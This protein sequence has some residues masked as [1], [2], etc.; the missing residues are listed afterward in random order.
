[1][2]ELVT[3]N[4]GQ[5]RDL[6]PI[7]FINDGN[8][9]RIEKA[10]HDICYKV[11]GRLLLI[12]LRIALKIN[13][14]HVRDYSLYIEP[15]SSCCVFQHYVPQAE[16]NDNKLKR[17]DLLRNKNYTIITL[18]FD[19]LK[20]LRYTLF[21]SSEPNN[22]II[23][24]TSGLDQNLE[25]VDIALFHEMVHVFHLFQSRG[26]ENGKAS[27]F[28]THSLYQCGGFFEDKAQEPIID[29]TKHPLF[30]YYYA[31][32]I[33][34]TKMWK[35]QMMPWHVWTNGKVYRV[36]F[37]EMLT[38]VGLPVDQ[39]GY[40]PGD[41]LSEN[42]YRAE[43]GVPLRFGHKM[44]TYYE[45]KKVYDNVKRC[46]EQ[47]LSILYNEQNYKY[48]PKTPYIPSKKYIDDIGFSKWF[49]LNDAYYFTIN[50]MTNCKNF[51]KQLYYFDDCIYYYLLT[52]Y[53]KYVIRN[54]RIN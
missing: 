47:N 18:D 49:G 40:K 16:V 46:V 45:S 7:I 39:C 20:K 3:S 41:E 1:M 11:S 17:K 24:M 22:D 36:N 9:S 21:S 50:S 38:I 34:D 15:G 51:K 48:E 32:K 4:R 37:E 12:R 8:E 52:D 5:N 23:L 42:L 30:K 19:I 28:S 10:L 29:I 54:F 2:F 33:D 43:K 13:F 31:Q 53:N 35:V 27:V 14:P 44:F 26:Y 25:N 6:L